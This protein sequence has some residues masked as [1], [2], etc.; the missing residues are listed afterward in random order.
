[1]K[2]KKVSKKR[3]SLLLLLPLGIVFLIGLPS[4]L[5]HQVI[6][7]AVDGCEKIGGEVSLEKDILAMNWSFSCEK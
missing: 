7:S 5:N 1:M 2:S 3:I 6:E 4:Y